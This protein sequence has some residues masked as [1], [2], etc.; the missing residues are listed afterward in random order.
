MVVRVDGVRFLVRGDGLGGL[1]H[2]VQAVPRPTLVD[3][4]YSLINFNVLSCFF[5]K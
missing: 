5:R 3:E 2:L 1:P 4:S